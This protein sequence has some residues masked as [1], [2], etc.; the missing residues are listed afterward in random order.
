MNKSQISDIQLT[1]KSDELKSGQWWEWC[2]MVTMA[3]GSIR[4]GVIESDNYG[5]YAVDTLELID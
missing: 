1:H 3:D 4:E 2:C 5:M